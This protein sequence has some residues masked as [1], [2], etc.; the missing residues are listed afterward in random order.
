M[1]CTEEEFWA[2]CERVFNTPEHIAMMKADEEER[3]AELDADNQFHTQERG[4]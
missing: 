1:E 2:N 3:Q 4:E